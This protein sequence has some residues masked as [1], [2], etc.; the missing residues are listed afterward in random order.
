MAA[1]LFKLFILTPMSPRI[2]SQ[3]PAQL[4]VTSVAKQNLKN[5]KFSALKVISLGH[6]LLLSSQ[7]FWGVDAEVSIL[8]HSL[9]TSLIQ[10]ISNLLIA[11][12]CPHLL[13]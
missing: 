8:L 1:L 11:N 9:H 13:A 4:A 6:A 7:G 2:V 10:T 12:C 3:F 5:M